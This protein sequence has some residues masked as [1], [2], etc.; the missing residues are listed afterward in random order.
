MN[1]K[2]YN[3]YKKYKNFK[4]VEYPKIFCRNIIFDLLKIIKN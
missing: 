4:N 2:I 3:E 1:I